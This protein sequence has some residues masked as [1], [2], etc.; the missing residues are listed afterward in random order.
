[1]ARRCDQLVACDDAVSRAT[2]Q[3]I[4]V[5]VVEDTLA[6][7]IDIPVQTSRHIFHFSTS[8]LAIEQVQVRPSK[9]QFPDPDPTGLRYALQRLYSIDRP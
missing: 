5:N 4:G 9:C 6:I 8:D 1:M 2:G 7:W 3:G